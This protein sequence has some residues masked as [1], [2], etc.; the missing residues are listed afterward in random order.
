ME[1]R[2]EPQR[3]CRWLKMWSELYIY[4]TSS[5]GCEGFKNLNLV[6]QMACDS[7]HCQ[8][9]IQGLKT[10]LLLLLLLLASSSSSFLNRS[11]YLNSITSFYC[12]NIYNS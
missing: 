9:V 8:I 1:G 7:W 4:M 2:E 3:N 10:K 12:E 11:V 6:T 5:L